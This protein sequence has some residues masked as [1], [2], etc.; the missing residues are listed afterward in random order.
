V[1]IPQA[2]LDEWKHETQW[3]A[4]LPQF[5]APRTSFAPSGSRGS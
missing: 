2:L 3:L 5:A 1:S 4:D